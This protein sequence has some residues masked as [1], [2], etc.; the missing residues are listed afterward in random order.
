MNGINLLYDA[1]FSCN[2]TGKHEKHTKLRKFHK[3]DQ[4]FMKVS[5][6]VSVSERRLRY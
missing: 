2:I 1:T 3:N 4:C 6:V 5:F